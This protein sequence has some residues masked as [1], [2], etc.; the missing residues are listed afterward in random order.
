[1]PCPGCNKIGEQRNQHFNNTSLI[2]TQY[3]HTKKHFAY[4][5]MV[6]E[7]DKVRRQRR[8]KVEKQG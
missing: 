6:N 7:W 4:I 2:F 8:G 3:T 5:K 1:M